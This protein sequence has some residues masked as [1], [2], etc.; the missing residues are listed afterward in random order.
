MEQSPWLRRCK[1]VVREKQRDL[2][3]VPKYCACYVALDLNLDYGI[4]SEF[5]QRYGTHIELKAQAR[6]RNVLH[7]KNPIISL[8]I[9]QCESLGGIERTI[10]N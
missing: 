4:V 7:L 10:F 8:A 9:Y 1:G 3:T 6:E 5:R 2:F